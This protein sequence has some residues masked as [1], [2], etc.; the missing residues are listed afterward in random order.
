MTQTMIPTTM[1]I[2]SN[3]FAVFDACCAA[4]TS[5][6]RFASWVLQENTI[7][8]IPEIKNKLRP[9]QINSLFLI[10]RVQK[11]ISQS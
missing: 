11:L 10:P 6:R 9:L 2:M 1:V 8:A 7:P 5:P 4:G 3:V